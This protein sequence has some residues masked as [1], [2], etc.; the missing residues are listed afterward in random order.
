MAGQ[1]V[2]SVVADPLFTDAAHG[3]YRLRPE[4]PALTR[5]FKELPYAEMGLTRTEFR[6]TLPRF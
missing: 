2:H 1:D 6:R 3:D 5:G 4:S